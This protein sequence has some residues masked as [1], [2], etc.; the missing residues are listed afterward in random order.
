MNAPDKQEAQADPDVLGMSDD[1]FMEMSVPETVPDVDFLDEEIS[2]EQEI[3]PET[4]EE[5]EIDESESGAELEPESEDED[6]NENEEVEE[7]IRAS[8]DE[9][10]D[11]EEQTE[12]KEEV[13]YKQEY[14]SLF[15]PFKAN[16]RNMTVKTLDEVKTLMKQGANYNKKMSEIKPHLRTVKSLAKAGI[17]TDEQLNYLLDLH[18]K[19]PEAITKLVKEAGISPHEIDTDED[20]SYTPAN[21][22]ASNEEISLDQVLD[23]ISDSPSYGRTLNVIGKEWDAESREIIQ[24]HQ[25]LIADIN[26]NIERGVFDV[27]DT[28]VNRQRSLGQLQGISDLLAYKQVGEAL[29]A[30]GGF[31]HLHTGDT[32]RRETA[33]TKKVIAPKQKVEDPALKKRR[34]AASSNKVVSKSNRPKAD[35]NFLEMSD[36]EFEKQFSAALQ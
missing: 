33:P 4:T 27:I 15:A 22:M 8:D 3:E 19:V 28:E 13:D 14:D 25:H 24:Q 9:G 6:N 7:E 18:N 5:E 31:N 16:G 1:A 12:E 2:E 20:S 26:D 32:Q 10:S 36:A 17:T 30:T 35:F 34:K 11:T 29:E 23:S 21:N